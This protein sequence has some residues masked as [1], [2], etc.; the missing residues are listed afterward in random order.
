M[1]N[2]KNTAKDNGYPYDTCISLGTAKASIRK[3]ARLAFFITLM[4]FFTS[5]LSLNVS[6]NDVSTYNLEDV[7]VTIDLPNDFAVFT[8]D[9]DPN[10][11]NL[12]LYGLT[13]ESMETLM[14]NGNIYLNAWN[15]T[16]DYE[17]VVTMTDNS[18]RDFAMFSDSTLLTMMSGLYDE[19]EK[20]GISYIKSEIYNTKNQK[21]VKIYISQPSNGTT[22]YGLQYY[23]VVNYK[24]TNITMHSYS[25]VIDESR[26][27]ILE[28]IVSS[29][30]FA[31]SYVPDEIIQPTDAFLYTDPETGISFRVPANW[32]K[33]VFS[34]ERQFLS[35]K[36]TSIYDSGISIMFGAVDVWN[37]LSAEERKGLSRKD[38]N[39]Q[40]ITKSDVAE[41]LNIKESEI[42]IKTYG[43]KEYFFAETNSSQ[44]VLGLPLVIK[45]TYLY[46]IEN[47][48]DFSFQ[49]SSDST[50]PYYKD[51]ESLLESV[52]YPFTE[53][54]SRNLNS[55]TND[56]AQFDNNN[57]WL[58]N[59]IF[60]LLITVII[61]PTPIWIYR[62]GIKKA[63][64][65]P[66]KAK[67]IVIIDAIIVTIIWAL[68]AFLNE[69]SKLS[70]VAII[71]WSSICY[72]SLTKGK[73]RLTAEPGIYRDVSSNN[74]SFILDEKDRFEKQGNARPSISARSH[75]LNQK[76]FCRFC[77]TELRADSVF[78]HKCGKKNGGI[79]TR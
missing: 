19:Y 62:Y 43:G 49:F 61:H 36:F 66:N 25:G 54:E 14:K 6:A 73:R 75:T 53:S 78:C 63:P 7:G 64:V 8:R 60:S 3:I 51:F 24:A 67:K 56:K 5:I 52:K 11:P 38:I 35:A 74:S 59:L 26:E 1:S 9:I 23:T 20:L 22:V 44:D 79:E 27:A 21:Y 32:E 4:L 12:E 46:R 48:Y 77:G 55:S 34:K 65:E 45:M 29:A 37:S 58:S 33:S 15:T 42:R 41:M 70:F 47:G 13:K 16:I 72:S 76:T 2:T 18:I 30:F 69:G 40:A 68:F 28:K 31:D 17:I 10:D 50:S 39:N 57:S 71:L